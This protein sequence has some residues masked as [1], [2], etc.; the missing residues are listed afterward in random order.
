MKTPFARNR[1]AVTLTELLVVL[2]I[3]SLLAT[4]AV[5]VYIQKTEQAR[6]AIAKQETKEIALANEQ[7][8]ALYGLYVPIHL[9]DNLG[10]LPSGVS[11]AGQTRDDFINDSSLSSVAVMDP[12]AIDLQGQISS[13][14]LLNNN[15]SSIS[16]PRAQT[17]VRNWAGPFLAP[18]RTSLSADK[19]GNLSSSGT[20]QTDVSRSLVLDP[21]GRPYRIYSPVGVVGQASVSTVPSR[22]SSD[23]FSL[24][25][26]NGQLTTSDDRF[27][28][29]AIVSLGRDGTSDT[30]SGNNFTDDIF[31]TFGVVPGESFYHAF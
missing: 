10:D 30:A 28:R 7:V 12:L 29:W 14:I 26:D 2:A 17:L 8:A 13:P 18:H 3:I 6:I 11:G 19:A 4:I 5:P 1:R 16:D 21:W 9:L 31:Y 27:D 20:S 22:D 25:L 24:D 15:S 23:R